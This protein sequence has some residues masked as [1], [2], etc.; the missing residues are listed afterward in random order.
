MGKKRDISLERKAQVVAL[1]K[2]EHSSYAKIA[3]IVGISKSSVANIAKTMRSS[4]EFA[5]VTGNKRSNCRRP[6][7]TTM[8]TDRRIVQKALQ[9]RNKP[10]GEILKD[11]NNNGVR[12][13]LRTLERLFKENNLS[14]R[15]PAKKPKLTKVMRQ[16]RL[17]WAQLLRS[18]RSDYWNTVN[19]LIYHISFNFLR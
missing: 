7:K 15:R 1:L 13:S 5:V 17:Y 19:P 4:T 9:E 8:R 2:E 14:C 12:I 3:D 16:K 11:L 18:H 6:R 10:A